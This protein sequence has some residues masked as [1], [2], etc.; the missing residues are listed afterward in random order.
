MQCKEAPS[1][2]MSIYDNPAAQHN[3]HSQMYHS[4]N[5]TESQEQTTTNTYTSVINKLITIRIIEQRDKRQYSTA[6][7]N[8]LICLNTYIYS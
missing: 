4:R 2:V 3:D 6:I 5:I 7:T 1:P 8:L